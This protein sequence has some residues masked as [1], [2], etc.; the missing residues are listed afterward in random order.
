MGYAPEINQYYIRIINKIAVHKR[1][2][3]AVVLCPK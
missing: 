2:V 1:H 3:S